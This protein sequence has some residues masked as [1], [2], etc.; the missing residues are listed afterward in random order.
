MRD[1]FGVEE[2]NIKI[3]TYSQETKNLPPVRDLDR[4]NDN[5]HQVLYMKGP[6]ILNEL[7]KSIGEL[8]FEKLLNTVYT[9][10][11]DT[12]EKFIDK[13]NEITNQEIGDFFIKLLIQ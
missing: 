6:L 13:L 3:N 7:K 9:S 11:T 4:Q 12:T 5:A 8:K 1:T 2:F 10:N